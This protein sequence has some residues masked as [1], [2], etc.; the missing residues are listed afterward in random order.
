MPSSNFALATKY[1]RLFAV[2][3]SLNRQSYLVDWAKPRDTIY[4]KT[5]IDRPRES[6]STASQ[7][8]LPDNVSVESAGLVPTLDRSLDLLETLSAEP[9]GMTLSQ[10]SETLSAPKN[11]MFRITQTLLSHGYLALDEADL[12]FRLTPKLR[13]L[14]PPRWR[15]IGLAEASRE[16]MNWLRDNTGETVQLGVLNEQEGVIIDQVEGTQP[17]RIVVNLGLRFAL[18]NNA[19][20]KLLLAYLAAEQ[21]SLTLSALKL[22]A[23]TPRT[24]TTKSGLRRECERIIAAGY[25]TDH[26]EADDGVHCIAAPIFDSDETVAGAIW[27]S[28]PAKRLPKSRFRDF[29]LQVS[30]AGQRIS[31]AIGELG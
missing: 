23:T 20:G 8:T 12:A 19:P 17:L 15:G 7:V 22:T 13:K 25:S 6:L 31:R 29:G 21:Q 9:R 11:F 14:S 2:S 30:A 26:A 18:H 1:W 27:I 5:S 16:E 24:I 28:G 4:R 3:L 10:L